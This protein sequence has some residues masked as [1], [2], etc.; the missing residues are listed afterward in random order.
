MSCAVLSC[1]GL[2]DFETSSSELLPPR[3]DVDLVRYTLDMDRK[4]EVYDSTCPCTRP[5]R[6]RFVHLPLAVPNAKCRSFQRHLNKRA[7]GCLS[8][9]LPFQASWQPCGA[10]AA[11]ALTLLRFDDLCLFNI[12][13]AMPLNFLTV[14]A[15]K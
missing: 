11:Q 6:A 13:S 5:R 3:S 7:S 10:G 14:V 12:S 1:R 8:A 9:S 2:S 15:T 4:Y